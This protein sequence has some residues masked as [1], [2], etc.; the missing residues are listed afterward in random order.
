M[1]QGVEN[2]PIDIHYNK[3]LGKAL[4]GLGNTT[5][6]QYIMVFQLQLLCSQYLIHFVQI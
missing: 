1:E 2:L 6:L 5:K 3:L 4:V